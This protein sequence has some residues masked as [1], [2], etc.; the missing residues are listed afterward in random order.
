ML[1]RKKR[2]GLDNIVIEAIGV[3]G[4]SAI[5]YRRNTRAPERCCRGTIPG[6]T[7]IVTTHNGSNQLLGERRAWTTHICHQPR[8]ETYEQYVEGNVFVYIIRSDDYI[9]RVTLA[10][11]A[12][13]T[14]AM[15]V[16]VFGLWQIIA[17]RRPGIRGEMILPRLLLSLD[18]NQPQTPRLIH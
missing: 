10:Q 6:Y 12:L 8:L 17:F 14:P 3:R 16:P 5:P 7:Q 9:H 4:I 15:D 2:A 13:C 1:A 11:S 18:Y